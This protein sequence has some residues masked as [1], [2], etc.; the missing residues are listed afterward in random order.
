MGV[1]SQEK[2]ELVVYQLKDVAQVWYEQWKD[3]RSIRE[4]RVTWGTFRKTFLDRF[5]CIELRE[6]KMQEFINLCQAN[7]SVKEYSL[8]FTQL[9]QYAPTIVE[10]S[11]AKMN[12]W[13]WGYKPL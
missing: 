6:I 11:R 1:T 9:C 10:D 7:M 13:L 5:F 4:G 3:Q 12:K 2:A 8:N